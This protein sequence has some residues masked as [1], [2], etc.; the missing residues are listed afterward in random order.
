MEKQEE[1]PEEEIEDED[2]DGV[3]LDGAALLK[4]A[5]LKGIADTDTRTPVLKHDIYS[6][7]EDIDGMPLDEDIDGVPLDPNQSSSAT[8]FDVEGAFGKSKT[9]GSFVPSKWETVDASQIEAQAITTSKWETLDPVA[10]DPPHISL[11]SGEDSDD[12]PGNTK[13]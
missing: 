5:M 1:E 7:E 2:L 3:P 10:P 12:E 13:R 6:D 4:S 9:G 8:D 11:R